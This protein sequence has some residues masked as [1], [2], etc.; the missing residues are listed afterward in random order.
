MV[1]GFLG[2]SDYSKS[3]DGLPAK[4]VR[5]ARWAWPLDGRTQSK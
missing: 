1:A 5:E 2:H 3:V 4:A